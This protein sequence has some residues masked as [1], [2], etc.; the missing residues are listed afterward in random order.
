M[1][2][3]IENENL[4]SQVSKV[5]LHLKNKLATLVEQFE[6]VGDVRGHGLFLAI[7]WVTDKASRTPDREGAKAIVERLKRPLSYFQCRCPSQCLKSAPAVSFQSGPCGRIFHRVRNRSIRDRALT[8]GH[9][10]RISPAIRHREPSLGALVIAGYLANFGFSERKHG[11]SRRNRRTKAPLR[12]V[13]IALVTIR[14]QSWSPSR[15][16]TRALPMVALLYPK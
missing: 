4:Q 14:C 6:Q 15:I 5:G 3:V 13:C 8:H 11:V 7:D 2:D 1:L 16:W 10:P 9:G 12:C